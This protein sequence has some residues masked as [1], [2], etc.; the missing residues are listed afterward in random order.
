[1]YRTITEVNSHTRLVHRHLIRSAWW[2]CISLGLHKWHC[3]DAPDELNEPVD[4]THFQATYHHGVGA[5]TPWKKDL[6]ANV[7][8][9]N[10]A[11]TEENRCV[12][13]CVLPRVFINWN[14]KGCQID[15]VRIPQWLMGFDKNSHKTLCLNIEQRR[16][17]KGII[18]TLEISRIPRLIPTYKNRKQLTQ[19]RYNKILL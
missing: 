1:M 3:L 15:L 19:P 13:V 10:R 18:C 9:L 5:L 4:S 14:V 7:F 2:V 6:P 16:N 12:R 17:S 11:S 8:Y